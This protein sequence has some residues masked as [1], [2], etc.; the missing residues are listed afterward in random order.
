MRKFFLLEAAVCLPE[1]LSLMLVLPLDT[2]RT[3]VSP[4]H[5]TVNQISKDNDHLI[6]SLSFGNFPGGPLPVQGPH[7]Q[8]MVRGLTGSHMPQPE[9]LASDNKD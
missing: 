3:K 1:H 6:K 5:L 8:S 7:V 4:N 2:Y 9:D